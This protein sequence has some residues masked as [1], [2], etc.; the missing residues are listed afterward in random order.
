MRTYVRRSFVAA[1]LALGYFLTTLMVVINPTRVYMACWAPIQF[2]LLAGVVSEFEY[3]GS[4]QQ[5]ASAAIVGPSFGATLALIIQLAA[6]HLLWLRIILNVVFMAI[7]VAPR[8]CPPAVGSVSLSLI[9]FGVVENYLQLS[10]DSGP[11]HHAFMYSHY[12][13]S[14]CFAAFVGFFVA[15][16]VFP[17]SVRSLFHDSV[18]NVLR[19]SAERL[20]RLASLLLADVFQATQIENELQERQKEQIANTFDGY[21]SASPRTSVEII[22]EQRLS[23]YARM[24]TLGRSESSFSA[25]ATIFGFAEESALL[26]GGSLYLHG[27]LVA[28]QRLLPLGANELTYPALFYHAPITDWSQII[29]KSRD[30]VAR[31]GGLE[32]VILHRRGTEYRAVAMHRLYR[33]A[34]A[35]V[36]RLWARLASACNLLG[37]LVREKEVRWFHWPENSPHARTIFR[38]EK[39]RKY[40]DEVIDEKEIEALW[41]RVTESGLSGYQE[42]W[43]DMAIATHVEDFNRE[44]DVTKLVRVSAIVPVESVRVA[45]FS[46]VLVHRVLD[47]VYELRESVYQLLERQAPMSRQSSPWWHWAL[48]RL[49]DAS[50]NVFM[51]VT[52]STR[53][54]Y[55]FWSDVLRN[56]LQYRAADYRRFWKN[57]QWQLIFLI[58]YYIIST[59]AIITVVCIPASSNIRQQWE[60]ILGYLSVVVSA[61]PTTES[62]VSVALSRAAGGIVGAALGYLVLVKPALAVNAFFVDG[63]TVAIVFVMFYCNLVDSMKWLQYT[64]GIA[65]FIFTVVCMCQYSAPVDHAVW[66]A[67]VGAMVCTAIGVGVIILFTT[68]L[69]PRMASRESRRTLLRGFAASVDGAIACW[70]ENLRRHNCDEFLDR[71]HQALHNIE[72]APANPAVETTTEE[73]DKEAEEVQN[74]RVHAHPWQETMAINKH[75]EALATSVAILSNALSPSFGGVNQFALWKRGFFRPPQFIVDGNVALC[76]VL[77]RLEVLNSIVNRPPIYGVRF[78]GAMYRLFLLALEPEFSAIFRSLI[79]LTGALRGCLESRGILEDLFGSAEALHSDAMRRFENRKWL[80]QLCLSRKRAAQMQSKLNAYEGNGVEVA[81]G[82]QGF[83]IMEPSVGLAL[84]NFR[85]R[86]A[87][88]WFRMRRRALQ[89]VHYIRDRYPELESRLAA[90]IAKMALDESSSASFAEIYEQLLENEDLDRGPQL[91]AV[92]PLLRRLMQL[93]NPHYHRHVRTREPRLSIAREAQSASEELLRSSLQE[94]DRRSTSPRGSTSPSRASF[95]H[96]S[97]SVAA[98]EARSCAP[99]AEFAQTVDH[100]LEKELIILNFRQVVETKLLR[101]ADASAS[102]ATLPIAGVPI[103]DFVHFSTFMYGLRELFGSIDYAARAIGSWTRPHHAEKL[104]LKR[105]RPFY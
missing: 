9:A 36:T 98:E 63:I 39:I 103:D 1:Q 51:A 28:L 47:S 24:E 88:L 21:H 94:D 89:I 70:E 17:V 60:P 96:A 31:I 71:F 15:L 65:I 48:N 54:M 74:V 25:E 50:W 57:N 104:S 30:L 85:R 4:L 27:S 38:N 34:L 5:A 44:V 92:F 22:M 87:E 61:R 37:L 69:S 3:V 101:S 18:E 29:Y 78:S 46:T 84:L 42:F 90:H 45:W 67:A 12:I 80:L 23:S 73:R 16:L 102:T 7:L 8:L 97:E 33:S 79:E 77:L 11:G 26:Q 6:G 20:S 40:L 19:E 14:T 35:D 58:K 62:A 32:S 76:V 41:R 91:V 72:A 81:D 52:F 43:R 64:A 99:D 10:L 75:I 82:G 105:G 95:A 59:A 66:Q 2:A 83:C 55:S 53:A 93:R 100:E 68:A 56:V 13:L 86:R 49:R